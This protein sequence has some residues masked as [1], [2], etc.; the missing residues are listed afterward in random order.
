MRIAILMSVV[1]S[2]SRDI[3]ISLS[4]LG[5]EIF[6][7]DL[8]DDSNNACYLSV[9]DVGMK[10][11]INKLELHCTIVHEINS[12]PYGKFRYFL[13]VPSL[14]QYLRHFRID[15]LLSLYAGGQAVTSFLTGFR[16][17]AVYVVGSDILYLNFIY[18]MLSKICLTSAVAVFANGNYLAEQ[19]GLVAPKAKVKSLLLGVETK[20][21]SPSDRIPRGPIKI[22]CSRGFEDVYNNHYIL[23]ALACMCLKGLPIF[24]V[25]FVSSGSLLELNKNIAFKILPNSLLSRIDFL[26]GVT[27][28]QLIEELKSSDIYIS[29]SRSDGTSTALLE[30]LSCG[31]FPILSDIP[32]NREW[33]DPKERNGMLVPLDNPSQFAKVLKVAI[34]RVSANRGSLSFNRRLVLEKADRNVNMAILGVELS[35]LVK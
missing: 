5:H 25:V 18:R 20:L 6:I 10:E 8:T 7:F 24:R 23:E 4:R 1:S 34:L 3:A 2:W 27:R 31:L 30:A 14:N 16:P 17:Y 35:S 9:A 21:F 19:T 11:E 33:I 29:V 32:Q 13:V 12:R 26:G 15:L 28:T 22:V